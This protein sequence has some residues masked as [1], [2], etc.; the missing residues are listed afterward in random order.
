M[1]IGITGSFG[2]GK[3]TVAKMFAKLGAH[4]IDAD[5]VYHSLIRPGSACY[6]KLIKNFGKGILNKAGHIDRN[7]LGKIVFKERPMLMLLNKLVHPEVIKEIRAAARSRKEK[8]IIIEAALLLESGF[9]KEVDKVIL[10][11]NKNEEQVKRIRNDRGLSS[12]QTLERI[13]MQ[14]PFKKKLALADF[15][16]DNSG[17]KADTLTQVKMIWK[18]KG[19]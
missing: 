6:K 9:H 13:R 12:R 17:S 19:V 14:M 3:T 11:A 8:V 15:I 16:I 10:V 4:V 18:R 5:R 2:S 1:I 7:K